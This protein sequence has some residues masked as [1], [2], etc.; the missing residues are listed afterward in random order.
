M[1]LLL[2][3]T[4]AHSNMKN[5]WK[6]FKSLF[7]LDYPLILKKEN[8]IDL[9]NL[10]KKT[11]KELEKLGRKIGVELDKRHTKDKLIKQIKKACK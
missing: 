4:E 6:K 10:N 2:Q 5:L 11:K 1:F 3:L 7:N 9:K 8:E